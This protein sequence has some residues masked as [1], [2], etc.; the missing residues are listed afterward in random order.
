MYWYLLVR[1]PDNIAGAQVRGH[2][3]AM[4]GTTSMGISILESRYI[5]QSGR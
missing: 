2:K 1:G 4:C 3:L 5:I